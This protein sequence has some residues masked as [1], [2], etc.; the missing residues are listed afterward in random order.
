MSAKLTKDGLV[1]F[2]TGNSVEKFGLQVSGNKVQFRGSANA[3]I[4]LSNIKRP[5]NDTDVATKEYIDS[6]ISEIQWLKNC[7]VETNANIDISALRSGDTIQGYELKNL[8]RIL[9]KNQTNAVLN[10]VYSVFD[11]NVPSRVT[12]LKDDDS[13]ANKA[14][15]VLNSLISYVTTNVSGLGDVV[16]TDPTYWTIFSQ[17]TQYNQ[18]DGVTITNNEIA[19]DNSVIRSSGNQTINGKIFA[20]EFCATSDSQL[21][22]NVSTINNSLML[23]NH[24]QGYQYTWTNDV[25][26]KPCYGVLAQDLQAHDQLQHLV[27]DNGSN[28]SVNY[29]GIIALLINGVNELNEQL[30]LINS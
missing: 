8:D 25:D 11:D 21:K 5:E 19:L 15:Y 9:V 30:K 27:N 10:G 7:H 4:I 29:L 12:L 22:N 6:I 13:N 3:S 16:G 23:L 2:E 26:N 1:F 20:T 17:D 18:G 28:L 24:I 14:V